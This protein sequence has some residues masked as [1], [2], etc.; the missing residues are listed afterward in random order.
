MNQQN[1]QNENDQEQPRVTGVGGIFFYSANP[2]ETR[3]WY[4]KNLGFEFTPWG[5]SGFE[6]NNSDDPAKT[7][8]LEW[9]LFKEGDAYFAPSAKPFM[10]NYRVNN[11][12]A[13][14]AQLMANGVTI[15]DE[16]TTYDYGKFLHIM[17][18]DGHKIE[19]WE[20]V[21]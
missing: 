19:L 14:R 20:P 16:I 1:K 5:S 11:L 13:L 6:S 15:L 21:S 8:R 4:A 7:D 10:V 2:E 12:E 3:A 18:A 9:C 17:D